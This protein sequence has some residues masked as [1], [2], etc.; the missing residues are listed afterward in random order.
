MP[1]ASGGVG[2]SATLWANLSPTPRSGASRMDSLRAWSRRHSLLRRGPGCVA[3]ELPTLWGSRS[4]TFPDARR[5]RVRWTGTKH[6]V[7]CRNLL[8]NLDS[9][10]FRLVLC[11]RR[12]PPR[13][14]RT[15]R[16]FSDLSGLRDHQAP[17]VAGASTAWW[18]G[19]GSLMSMPEEERPNQ[20]A[21]PSPAVAPQFHS[22]RRGRRVGE[23]GRSL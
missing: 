9:I 4:R 23:P 3:H 14:G 18:K 11:L 6:S 13:F 5:R 17:R 12:L 21:A 19:W 20:P 16:C 1:C 2:K 10:I 15:V 22:E 7:P 8:G